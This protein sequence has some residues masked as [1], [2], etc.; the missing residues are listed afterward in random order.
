MR[1]QRSTMIAVLEEAVSIFKPSNTSSYLRGQVSR[2]YI[3]LFHHFSNVKYYNNSDNNSDEDSRQ[4]YGEVNCSECGNLCF[5]FV[6]LQD[7]LSNL[8]QAKQDIMLMYL[9]GY[10]L[11]QISLSLDIEQEDIVHVLKELNKGTF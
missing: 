7:Y 4:H 1:E 10:T 8:P 9:Q 6:G 11:N 5:S 3:K 2:F